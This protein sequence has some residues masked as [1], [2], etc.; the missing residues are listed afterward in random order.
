M[1]THKVKITTHFTW[2]DEE[3]NVYSDGSTTTPVELTISGSNPEV[4]DRTFTVAD[5]A[6]KE[7]LNDDLLATFD[8]FWIQSN[9]DI[10][11][12]LLCNEG[13]TVSSNNL[14]N[15]AILKINAGHPFYLT[16]DDSRTLGDCVNPMN[17]SNYLTEIDL[18]EDTARYPAGVFNRIEVKNV[19]GASA[20][21]RV[22]AIRDVS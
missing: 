22:F 14:E 10:E 1:A 5:T 13:G 17:E 16:N 15:A 8:F 20:C 19:G 4:Y 12:Q 9:Q 6:V 18:W 2:T 11:I 7:V 3:S 21:I